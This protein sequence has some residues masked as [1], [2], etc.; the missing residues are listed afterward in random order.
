MTAPFM[1]DYVSKE[2]LGLCGAYFLLSINLTNIVALTIIPEIGA[3]THLRYIY[4][5]LGIFFIAVVLFLMFAIKDVKVEK[6]NNSD[7]N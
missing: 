3:D 2:S 6:S 5:G 1:P 4:Y 7:G